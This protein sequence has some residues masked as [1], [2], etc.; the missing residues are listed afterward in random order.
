MTVYH[1]EIEDAVAHGLHE[2]ATA[3][4]FTSRGTRT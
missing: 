1:K 2:G 3:V 4:V